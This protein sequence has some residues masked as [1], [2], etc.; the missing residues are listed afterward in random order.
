MSNRKTPEEKARS[1]EYCRRY[2]DRNREKYLAL[3]REWRRKNIEK[4]RR[5]GRERYR[6]NP[7]KYRARSLARYYKR[8][9]EAHRE[10]SRKFRQRHRA[11]LQEKKRQRMRNDPTFALYQRVRLR[12]LMAVK[13]QATKKATRT[14]A[15]IGCSVKSLRSHLESQFEPGMNWQNMGRHGW[16]IDHIIPCAVFDLSRPDHQ[17]RC[18]HYTN[19]RPA[20]AKHNEA[21]GSR[22]EGELPLMYRHPRKVNPVS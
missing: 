5:Q 16:H 6:K 8:P 12:V 21:R 18:F 10:A 17:R 2:R 20:W 22:I 9:K 11:R 1:R 3:R 14:T 19:L 15:L 4:I 13:I 7:E